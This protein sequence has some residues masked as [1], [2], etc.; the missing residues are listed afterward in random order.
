MDINLYL[1]TTKKVR[2]PID[3]EIYACNVQEHVYKLQTTNY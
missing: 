3:S 1:Y 2:I